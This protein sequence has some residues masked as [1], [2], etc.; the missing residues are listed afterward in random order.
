MPETVESLREKLAKGGDRRLGEAQ[1]RSLKSQLHFHGTKR[2]VFN[3][4]LEEFAEANESII[5]LTPL[6]PL[7][8]SLWKTNSFEERQLALQI[9]L[10]FRGLLGER[11]WVTLAEW[12]DDVDNAPLA[13]A[14][15]RVRAWLLRRYP[16]RVG[17]LVGW[18]ASPNPWKR[19]SAAA[20]LVVQEGQEKG[21]EQLAVPARQAL[22]VIEALLPDK[23]AAVQKM[24]VSVA[25]VVAREAPEAVGRT[26]EL[27]R[28]KAP[29]GVLR[30]IAE[31]LPD[32]LRKETLVAIERPPD[33]TPPV[34]PKRGAGAPAKT[35]AGKPQATGAATAPAA[36]A[37]QSGGRAAVART[38]AASGVAKPGHA[39]RPAAS[40]S[41]AKRPAARKPAAARGGRKAARAK[42]TRKAAARK[43]TRKLPRSKARKSARK[44]PAARRTSSAA[45]RPK[46]RD[47]RH[48]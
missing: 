37:R 34:A 20:S 40:R 33:P 47:R 23:D 16:E 21:P 41:T 43:P 46:P 30:A 27:L 7:L 9:L 1:R 35:V 44:S 38:A 12:S 28:A 22:R 31:R 5:S 17:T 8:T 2:P 45:R 3:K 26:L 14:T 48:R 19:R 18:C 10:E 39:A 32:R 6:D 24:T 36:G 25:R 13:D 4:V 11:E 15:G 29:K 42:P